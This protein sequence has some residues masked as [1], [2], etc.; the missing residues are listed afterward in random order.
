[1]I[2]AAFWGGKGLQFLTVC[3]ALREV[4]RKVCQIYGISGLEAQRGDSA[5]VELL[6]NNGSGRWFGV[7]LNVKRPGCMPGRFCFAALL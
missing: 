3:R 4:L 1:M 2:I 5:W 7:G 6:V